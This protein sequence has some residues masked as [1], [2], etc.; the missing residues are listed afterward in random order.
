MTS[1]SEYKFTGWPWLPKIPGE[2]KMIK[3]CRRF[4]VC[5]QKV[6]DKCNVP[7]A[8]SKGCIVPQITTGAKTNNGNN[9]ETV[10]MSDFVINNCAVQTYNGAVS[11][12][13]HVVEPHISGNGHYSH[14]QLKSIPWVK[15]HCCNEGGIVAH[16]WMT[17]YSEMK[18]I[19]LSSRSSVK[20]AQIVCDWDAMAVRSDKLILVKRKK[21]TLLQ[22]QKHTIISRVVIKGLKPNAKMKDFG[23][24]RKNFCTLD[25]KRFLQSCN[26]A[27]EK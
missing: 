12:I 20:L 10:S 24:D 6:P 8:V 7:L 2:R 18:T 16:L 13:N 23:I 21:I 5:N 15:K 9:R 26:K 14:H 11:L 27:F 4:T 1:Y 19:I 22:E 25:N 17:H 3:V